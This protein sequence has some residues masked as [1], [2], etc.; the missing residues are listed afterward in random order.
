MW[1]R[2]REKERGHLLTRLMCSRSLQSRPMALATILK[3]SPKTIRRIRNLIQGKEAYIVG[4]LLQPDDLEVADA[5]G[6]PILGPHPEVAQLYSS[7][8]GSKRVFAAA[9]VPA[10]PGQHDIYNRQQVRGTDRR[11]HRFLSS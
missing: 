10:P 4:G 1:S 5:L 6:L 11:P 9:G 3:Y 7:K 2:E 8:S